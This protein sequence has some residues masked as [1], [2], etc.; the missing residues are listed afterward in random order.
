MVLN[1]EKL[2]QLVS[3]KVVVD[4]FLDMIKVHGPSKNE[5][6]FAEYMIKQMESLGAEIYLDNGFETYGGNAPVIFAKFKGSLPGEGITFSVHMDVIEPHAGVE[7]IIE[8]DIIRTDGSTTLGGD[9]R[10]GCASVTEA[11]RVIKANNIEHQDI[12]VIMS[13]CEEVGLLGAKSIDWDKVPE[14]MMPSKK[15]LVV[16]NAGRAGLVAHTGPAR[17]EFEITFKGKKAHAGVEPEKGINAIQLASIAVANMN[18]GRIDELTTSNIGNIITEGPLNV[19]PDECKVIGEIRGHDEDKISGILDTYKK[20]CEK[21]VDN[22][23]GEFV[24]DIEQAFPALK[25]IDDLKFA[26]EICA[27]YDAIGVKSE[28]EVIGG[29]TDGNIYSLK[30]FNPAIIGVGMY[31]AHTLSENLNTEDLYNTTLAIVKYVAEKK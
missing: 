29:G 9:D 25:P 4:R 16:D 23:G 24:F 13:T 17:Y 8:G 3:K 15:M 10:G 5:I 1:R 11:L 12:Y 27:V 6:K 26:K 21:A 30:G 14:H 20:S 31:D 7:P 2:E 22:L 28:L 18:I 19:V